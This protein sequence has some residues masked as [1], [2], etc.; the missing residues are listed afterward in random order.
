MAGSSAAY[1]LTEG[2]VNA[3]EIKLTALGRKL[4]APE[5]EGDDLTARRE[6]ILSPRIS[7]EFFERY[8]RA[9]FPNI[10]GCIAAERSGASKYALG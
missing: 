3:A 10:K 5:Q 1:G 9:K 2:G 4:V 7:K 6:A 8:R